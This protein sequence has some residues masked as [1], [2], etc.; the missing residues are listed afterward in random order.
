ML[1]QGEVTNH[2]EAIRRYG[3][4]TNPYSLQA[5]QRVFNSRMNRHSSRNIQSAPIIDAALLRGVGSIIN[6]KP[7]AQANVYFRCQKV[8]HMN[9][10]MYKI[11]ARQDILNGEELY[12]DY[13]DACGD[14]T[15]N[16]FPRFETLSKHRKNPSWY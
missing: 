10:W 12:V 8:P 11:L 6:H 4:H 2:Q 1:Y 5:T 16:H 13:G 9:E 14:F 3:I 7:H 15:H